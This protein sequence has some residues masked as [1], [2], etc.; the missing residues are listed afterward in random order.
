MKSNQVQVLVVAPRPA[1]GVAARR[2]SATTARRCL[3]GARRGLVRQERGV[4]FHRQQ[5]HGTARVI[6]SRSTAGRGPSSAAGARR[7]ARSRQGEDHRGR[8][9]E[10]QIPS[11]AWALASAAIDPVDAVGAGICGGQS[12]ASPSVGGVVCG[13]SRWWAAVGRKE[14]ER[15]EIRGKESGGGGLGVGP[16]GRRLAWRTQPG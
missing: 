6:V 14:S 13:S 10:G 15:E 7:R 2:P 9:G 1:R 12:M 5:E 16:C 8:Q 4:G 3:P 11:I